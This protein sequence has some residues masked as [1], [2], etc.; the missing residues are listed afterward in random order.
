[1]CPSPKNTP[2]IRGATPTPCGK[3]WPT[4]LVLLTNTQIA[5]REEVRLTGAL[6]T[7]PEHWKRGGNKDIKLVKG[8]SL[9]E[10]RPIKGTL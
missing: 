4:L 1:L 5:G 7:P 3:K 6:K 9:K 8:P 2:E 10:L